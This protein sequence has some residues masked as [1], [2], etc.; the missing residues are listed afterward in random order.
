MN[1]PNNR[2]FR[3]RLFVVSLLVVTL[4][5]PADASGLFHSGYCFVNGSSNASKSILELVEEGKAGEERN[6]GNAK[7]ELEGKNLEADLH[8]AALA[9]GILQGPDC[10]SSTTSADRF[11][12]ASKTLP[13]YLAHHALLI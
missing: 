4:L 13:I 6:E 9:S 11:R 1:R 7:H 5:G 12:P 8:F 10:I 3:L 2:W